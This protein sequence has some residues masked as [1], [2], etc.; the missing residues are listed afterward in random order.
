MGS[1]YK[2][3]WWSKKKFLWLQRLWESEGKKHVVI[4]SKQTSAARH[5]KPHPALHCSVLLPV[6]SW[7]VA[8]LVHHTRQTEKLKKKRTKYKSRSTI[9]PVRFGPVGRI[10]WKARLWACSER[11]KEWWMMRV[12]MMTEMSWQVN[13]E[14]GGDMTGVA[15][16]M[17][18]GVD[19][20]NGHAYLNERSVLFNNKQKS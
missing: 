15:D 12:V 16:V 8:S 13:E 14:V 6:K 17:N 10:C 2:I 20:R 11:A 19:S 9:S 5:N 1:Q 7:R 4:E 18:Q 3:E